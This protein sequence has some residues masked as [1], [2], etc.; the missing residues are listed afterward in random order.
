MMGILYTE[1]SCGICKC[2][3]II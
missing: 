2:C 3:G 1:R